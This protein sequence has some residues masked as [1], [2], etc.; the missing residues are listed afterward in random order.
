MS[1]SLSTTDHDTIRDWATERGGTPARVK[2]TQR[3]STGI[4]RIMFPDAPH[5]H[6][7]ELEEISWEDFFKKFDEKKLC[8]VYQEE[9]RGN[10]S[11]FHKLVSR[12]G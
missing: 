5:S 11:N 6:H 8:L 9:T 2:G 1:E 4:I 7:D 12:E 3:D 10:K